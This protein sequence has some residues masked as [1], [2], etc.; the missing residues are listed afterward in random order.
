MYYIRARARRAQA[1]ADAEMA[2]L[3]ARMEAAVIRMEAVADR[4]EQLEEAALSSAFR[5]QRFHK[6][7]IGVPFGEASRASLD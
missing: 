4:Q 3:T 1:A 2:Q 5:A 7:S 6:A